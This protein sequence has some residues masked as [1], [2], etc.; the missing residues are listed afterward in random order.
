[1]FVSSR[2]SEKQTML[3]EQDAMLHA[4]LFEQVCFKIPDGEY[5][6]PVEQD[7]VS[8]SALR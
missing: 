5:H 4:T 1:M 6:T 3:P 8:D 7:A 2:P